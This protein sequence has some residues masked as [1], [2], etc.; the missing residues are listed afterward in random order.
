DSSGQTWVLREQA[1]QSGPPLQN[2]DIIKMVK[3]SLGDT[4]IIVKINSSKCQFDTSTDA[5]I[6]LKQSGA[7]DAVLRAVVG[8]GK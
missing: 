2:Q 7:S 8:A 1:V 4:L 3:A 6:E 5:L